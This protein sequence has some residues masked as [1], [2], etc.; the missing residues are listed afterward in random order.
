MV[1]ATLLCAIVWCGLAQ[2]TGDVPQLFRKALALQ[3][4]GNLQ[5]A[6]TIYQQILK[7]RP[8]VPP[9]P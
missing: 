2:N 1:L 3:Q 8:D 5:A 6:I 7:V 4:S 9:A